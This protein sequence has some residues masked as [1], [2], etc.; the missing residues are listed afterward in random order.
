MKPQIFDKDIHFVQIAC[1]QKMVTLPSTFFHGNRVKFHA[2]F[3][4]KIFN[5]TWCELNCLWRRE[6]DLSKANLKLTRIS[7]QIRSDFSLPLHS[8]SVMFMIVE[9]HIDTFELEK[10]DDTYPITRWSTY[11]T[12]WIF[13]MTSFHKHDKNEREKAF[14]IFIWAFFPHF[15]PVMWI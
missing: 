12:V 4:W 8:L 9:M 13:S 15:S 11:T 6:L 5:S 1:N 3:C 14:N 10:T 7:S 2:P